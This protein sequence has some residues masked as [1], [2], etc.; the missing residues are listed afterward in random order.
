M[1][2]NCNYL[3]KQIHVP[4]QNILPFCLTY[5]PKRESIPCSLRLSKRKIFSIEAEY[6]LFSGA[7]PSARLVGKAEKYSHRFF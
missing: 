6:S 1:L 5:C 2:F 3:T 7:M 4:K